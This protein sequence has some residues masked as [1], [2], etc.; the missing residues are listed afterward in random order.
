MQLLLT[1]DFYHGAR[2][3]GAAV[4]LAD[5]CP[6]IAF[7]PNCKRLA[8]IFCKYFSHPGQIG[9]CQREMQDKSKLFFKNKSC[10]RLSI[11]RFLIKSIGNEAFTS[12]NSSAF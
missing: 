10:R 6:I 12:A 8:R 4:A 11:H 3:G 5:E 2:T 1:R 9:G 7:A